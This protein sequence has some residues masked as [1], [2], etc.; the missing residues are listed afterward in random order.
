LT[1]DDATRRTSIGANQSGALIC[2]SGGMQVRRVPQ[3]QS[4]GIGWPGAR[5][6]RAIAAAMST[7]P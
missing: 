3:G 4:A 2:A 5:W 7:L 6:I 1:P